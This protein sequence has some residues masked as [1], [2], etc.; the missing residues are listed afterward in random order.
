MMVPKSFRMQDWLAAAFHD[1]ALEDGL[2]DGELLRRMITKHL[3]ERG[4]KLSDY[5]FTARTNR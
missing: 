2:Q 3:E 4:V 1:A 5:M